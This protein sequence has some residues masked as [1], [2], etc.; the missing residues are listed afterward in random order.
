M[1][2][3]TS[4]TATPTAPATEHLSDLAICVCAKFGGF[5]DNQL[6]TATAIALAESDGHTKETHVNSNGT[7]DY[8]LWQINSVHSAVLAGG[9][10]SSPV[11]NAKMAYQIWHGAKGS[12]QPWS[13]YN[14]G[15]YLLYMNRGKAAESNFFISGG[16]AMSA[17]DWGKVLLE[18]GNILSGGLFGTSIVAGKDV[19]DF[20]VDA[21]KSAYELLKKLLNVNTWISVSYILVGTIIL[22]L[23]GKSIAKGNGTYQQ[24]SKIAK[25][26]AEA[27]AMA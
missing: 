13:T 2:S 23:I 27:A 21:W 1:P 9:D 3:P 18:S 10:W 19:V 4:D 16:D 7:T 20:T 12:W 14:S 11:D 17:G 25:S 8:G 15:R 6:A 26:T 5:P 22:L 24:V